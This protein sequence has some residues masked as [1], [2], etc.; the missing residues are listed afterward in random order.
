MDDLNGKKYAGTGFLLLQDAVLSC[1]ASLLSVLLVR[2]LSEPIS[3]FSSLVLLWVGLA[4]AGTLVGTL[5]S[6]SHRV[7]RRWATLSSSW[8]LVRTIII[9]ESVLTLVLVTGLVKMP[10]T[11]LSV[12]AVLTDGMLTT[13]FLFYIRFAARLF[14]R[15]EVAQVKALSARQ[16]AVVAGTDAEAVSLAL[17]LS[18]Q[19][20]VVGF[21]TEDERMNG[22]IIQDIVVYHVENREQLERLEWRL[23]G[24][25]CVFL[26]QKSEPSGESGV[27]SGPAS[28]PDGSPEIS[29]PD[30]MSVVGRFLKRS[31]DVTASLVLMLLFLPLALLCALAVKLEDGGPALYK[32][33]RIGKGGKSFYILKFRSMRVDAEANGARLFGGDND[34]RLTR[35]GAFLRAH[36]LDELPQLWNVF[37]G[38]MS[39]IGY[40]PE[41]QVY[42]CQIMERNPRYRYLYQIRPGVTSYATLYNGYTD[43]LEKMLTR[44]DL[45][46]YYLRNHSL[47]FDA[48]VLGLTF[49]RIVSGKKF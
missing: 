5:A 4:L 30:G 23:G 7:V 20:N 2:W 13:L 32:Q 21:L 49:L 10:S 46:L 45:D 17:E 8:R 47:L 1:A 15:G 24:I 9:K 11:A 16:N 39:F 14:S 19:Y 25:D 22:R 33:E 18:K 34:P 37:R 48:R 3:G 44:L 35:T 31:F 42:I 26:P 38:D 41:R 43:S 12:V 28:E 29:V 6:G 27:Q 36:H 40:R